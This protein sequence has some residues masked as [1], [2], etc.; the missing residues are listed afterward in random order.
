M[1]RTLIHSCV[2][3]A[4][5]FGLAMAVIAQPRDSQHGHLVP[6]EYVFFNKKATAAVTIGPADIV[7][8]DMNSGRVLRRIDIANNIRKFNPF[9]STADYTAWASPNLKQVLF[10]LDINGRNLGFLF[11]FDERKISSA[12]G[13]YN[14]KLYGF[15]F[16]QSYIVFEGL[17]DP[18][19]GIPDKMFL[20]SKSSQMYNGRLD[21]FIP[22]GASYD[23]NI[24]YGKNTDSGG[25][26]K[27]PNLIVYDFVEQKTIETDLKFEKDDDQYSFFNPWNIY[28]SK[29][30]RVPGK[31]FDTFYNIE[32]GEKLEK[33]TKENMVGPRA[34]SDDGTYAVYFNNSNSTYKIDDL[35][36]GESYIIKKKNS[37]G[38]SYLYLSRIPDDGKQQFYV[39]EKKAKK[40][41]L[42]VYNIEDGSLVKNYDLMVNE[43][44]IAANKKGRAELL[45]EVAEAEQMQA[46]QEQQ[47]M[48]AQKTALIKQM[49]K[50]S[51]P[52]S[53]TPDT[54]LKTMR[55]D[56]DTRLMG[57]LVRCSDGSSVHLQ[58]NS[59]INS[60]LKQY[61]FQVQKYNANGTPDNFNY[62]NIT[63]YQEV[64]GQAQLIPAFVIN[65]GPMITIK[66][67]TEY[68]N[69]HVEETRITVNKNTCS[70]GG[71]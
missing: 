11:S 23:G 20:G 14:D 30:I 45:A 58:M 2:T 5:I 9:T 37:P 21:N 27:K 39:L 35:G 16:D 48:E 66:G 13:R 28:S 69:G 15:T 71:G 47:K 55:Y 53:Y 41:F 70:V 42:A 54:Q 57:A 40:S 33:T 3:A 10:T 38:S 61:T 12:D 17:R 29:W 8:W 51:L 63:T 18:N 56:N 31:G 25:F 32:T 43:Q 24:I 67:M 46:E 49:P 22:T 26:L 4:C 7:W 6:P 65:D 68:R 1:R 60:N 44:V 50:L 19:T 59:R 36:S 64:N 62:K 34:F 52:Y